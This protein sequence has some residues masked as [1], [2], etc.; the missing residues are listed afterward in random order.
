MGDFT[1]NDV[2]E[3]ID[4]LLYDMQETI[5]SLR[6]GEELTYQNIHH[7]DNCIEGLRGQLALIKKMKEEKQ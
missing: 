1:I 4:I 3:Y 2:E 6:N 5:Y 7:L